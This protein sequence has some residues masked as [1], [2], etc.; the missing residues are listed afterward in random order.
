MSEEKKEGQILS[1]DLSPEQNMIVQTIEEASTAGDFNDLTE[2]QIGATSMGWGDIS[3]EH[4]IEEDALG[5]AQD[6]DAR[7]LSK[8][9]V[10]DA[11][12][13]A[14]VRVWNAVEGSEIPDF[15]HL[16]F[17]DQEEC[18]DMAHGALLMIHGGKDKDEEIARMLHSKRALRFLLKGWAFAEEHGDKQTF[19]VAPWDTQPHPRRAPLLAFVGA[20][21]GASMVWDRDNEFLKHS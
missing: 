8:E 12:F 15:E 19:L 3:A 16:A 18:V 20:C 10:A 14:M 1:A 6:S 2:N 5:E 9:Q 11:A 4:G 17:D 21:R 7:F 13:A